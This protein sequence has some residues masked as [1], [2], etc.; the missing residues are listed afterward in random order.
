M[1]STF[2]LH[3][4]LVLAHFPLNRKF[5]VQRSYCPGADAIAQVVAELLEEFEVAFAVVGPY[6][7]GEPGQRG[8]GRPEA[9]RVAAVE[10]L[11]PLEGVHIEPFQFGVNFRLLSCRYV[12][13]L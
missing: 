9:P 6:M 12:R 13:L 1:S 5:Y 8:S 3:A 7:R 11:A 2:Q 4:P 10:V